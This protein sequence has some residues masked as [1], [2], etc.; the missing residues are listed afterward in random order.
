MDYEALLVGLVAFAKRQMKDLH[1]F[2]KSRLLVDQVEGNRVS[3]TEGAK[4]YR[5]E[6]INDTAPFHRFQITYIPKALNPKGEA[7]TGI[8]SI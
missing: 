7:L 6:V 5:D 1:V 8:A 4:R 3:K 2:V